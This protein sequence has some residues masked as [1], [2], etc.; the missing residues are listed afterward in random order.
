MISCFFFSGV[1]SWP[2]FSGRWWKGEGGEE[3]RVDER[4][5][6]GAGREEAAKRHTKE[7]NG[8]EQEKRKGTGED[9][10]MIDKNREWA[11]K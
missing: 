3:E 4:G 2:G 8:D 11:E 7:R 6:R 1:P 9:G 5:R 10:K